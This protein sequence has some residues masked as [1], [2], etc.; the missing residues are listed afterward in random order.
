M[1]HGGLKHAP[2]RT[3]GIPKKFHV[4]ARKIER[5]PENFVFSQFHVFILRQNACVSMAMHTRNFVQQK[6]SFIIVLYLY[7]NLYDFSYFSYLYL[8]C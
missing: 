6:Q 2:T 7:L 8:F 5:L 4:F 3:P 1:G